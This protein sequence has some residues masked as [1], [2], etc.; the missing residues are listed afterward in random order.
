MAGLGGV[1]SMVISK[2][3]AKH[4]SEKHVDNPNLYFFTN[5]GSVEWCRGNAKLF[6]LD[7]RKDTIKFVDWNKGEDSFRDMR[8]W[9]CASII[10]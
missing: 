1:I 5:P 10:L 9:P 7:I 3:A 2:R 6:G 8:L 4:T